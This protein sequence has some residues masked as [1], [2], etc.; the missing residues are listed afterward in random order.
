MRFHGRRMHLF[1]W[2]SIPQSLKDDM[3]KAKKQAQAR[4]RQIPHTDLTEW[5]PTTSKPAIVGPYEVKAHDGNSNRLFSYWSHKL[6][7]WGYRM[8][9]PELAESEYIAIG[10]DPDQNRTWRGIKEGK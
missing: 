6:Q 10:A 7:Q 5:N 3:S 8:P 9:T 1:R 4:A 2:P